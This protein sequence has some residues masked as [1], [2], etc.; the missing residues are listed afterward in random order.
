MS[1]KSID[2]VLYEISENEHTREKNVMAGSHKKVKIG[3]IF[4]N[5][6]R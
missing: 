4:F 3:M 2:Q 6:L 1:K 5:N